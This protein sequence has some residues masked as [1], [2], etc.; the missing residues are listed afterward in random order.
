MEDKEICKICGKPIIYGIPHVG[1]SPPFRVGEQ[2]KRKRRLVHPILNCPVGGCAFSARMQSTIKGHLRTIHGMG[3]RGTP[4]IFRKQRLAAALS[5]APPPALSAAPPP[6][7]T[8]A[9][10]SPEHHYPTDSQPDPVTELE[11]QI[12]SLKFP[13][14]GGK[15]KTL[16]KRKTKRKTQR[17]K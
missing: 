11:K 3:L 14:K 6:A 15:R 8:P 1:H 16:R 17:R 4:P 10:S 2:T 13:A 9:A 7:P 5:A 12:G